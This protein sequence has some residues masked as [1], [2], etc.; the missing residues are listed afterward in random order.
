MWVPG[1]F[2]FRKSRYGTSHHHFISMADGSESSPR[3]D[4]DSESPNDDHSRS[5][6]FIDTSTSSLLGSSSLGFDQPVAYGTN[7]DVPA[8]TSAMRKFFQ[9]FVG[10]ESTTA[11]YLTRISEMDVIDN[12]TLNLNC[13]HLREFDEDLYIRLIDFP[14]ERLGIA[15]VAAKAVYDSLFPAGSVNSLA[16]QVRPFNLGEARSVANMRVDDIDHLVAVR[17]LVIRTSPLIPDLAEAAMKCSHCGGIEKVRVTNCRVIEPSSCRLCRSTNCF[18]IQPS[19]SAFTDRQYLKLQEAPE[20]VRQ[21]LTPAI[22]HACIY[23]DL[24]DYA[25]PGDRVELTGIWRVAPARLHPRTRTR[26]V[27]AAYNGFLD[28]VHVRKQFAEQI[29]GGQ[30]QSWDEA[31]RTREDDFERQ[32]RAEALARDPDIYDKLVASF[33]PSIWK[34]N[35]VKKGLLC[36]LFGG[37]PNSHGFRADIHVLMV[38]DPAVGKSQL[39]KQTHDI[40]ARGLYTSG[41]G[42]SAAGL[43]AS[44]RRD[45]VS[46]EFVLE[47]GA[48][49]LSDQGVCC[50]DEFDKMSDGARSILH[51]VMEQQTVSIAKA[52]TVCRLNARASIVASANPRGSTYD[53]RV[54]LVKNIQMPPT[55]LSRF[56]LIYVLLDKID[57]EADA[58]FARHI[59]GLFSSK[60]QVE[61]PIPAAVL[62]DYIA[63]AKEHCHPKFTDEAADFLIEAYVEI[64]S[65]GGRNVVTATPR[66]FEG[67]IRLAEA[68]AK[69]RLSATVDKQDSEEALRLTREALQQ[70][71][72]DPATGLI[73]LDLITTGTSQEERMK[74]GRLGNEIVKVL[75]QEKSGALPFRQIV[76]RLQRS[77]LS[78]SSESE[79]TVAL[80]SLELREMIRLTF[81]NGEPIEAEL[82]H[83]EED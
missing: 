50:I 45:E 37:T 38:G 47:A 68:H 69:M 67:W 57:A 43:T 65:L 66:Q 35:D 54:S 73:D 15:D 71:A 11:L 40:A 2:L 26:T 33:A 3:P 39:L 5:F 42:S 70:A 17:G 34:M 41:K 25:R 72:T 30:Q 19:L 10:P 6:M 27:R 4:G 1:R 81:E 51:E 55:L 28:V 53:R 31:V 16:I 62:T 22:M 36:V 64:R 48:L 63:Y 78:N 13:C 29:E 82:V 76:A 49:V 79:V 18:E 58:Q 61:P 83:R 56:D 24:V 80:M 21:G 32:Q 9:T 52:G 12:Y 14:L 23:F 20:A 75:G 77:R 7:I 8:M 59:V 60:T 74:V 44:L 46:K